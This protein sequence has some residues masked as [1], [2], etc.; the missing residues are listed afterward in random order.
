MTDKKLKKLITAIDPIS[1][2]IPGSKFYRSYCQACGVEIR[3]APE[4]LLQEFAGTGPWCELHEPA[5]PR[6]SPNIPIRWDWPAIHDK[7]FHGGMAAPDD[8]NVW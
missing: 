2:Q 6:C 4:R 7:R 3:V 8:E 5:A 1:R